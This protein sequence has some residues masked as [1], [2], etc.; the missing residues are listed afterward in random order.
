MNSRSLFI[1]AAWAVLAGC[2]KPGDDPGRGVETAALPAVTVQTTTLALEEIPVTTEITGTVQAT[3]R[4][5]LASKLMGAIE[6]MPVSLGQRVKAGEVLVKIAAGE[7]S[8]R[9]AQAR[10]QLNTT[11][12]DLDRERALQAKGAS[13]N[14]T[15]RNLED[16]VATHEAQLREAEVMLGYTILRAPFDGVVSRKISNQ[17]DLAT[18][19]TTLLEVHGNAGFEVDAAVPETAASQLAVDAGVSV[20]IPATNVT[21]T[22]KIAEISSAVDTRA[23]AVAIKVAVPEGVEVRSGQFARLELPGEPRR[24]IRVPASAVSRFGQIERVF[25][26][27]D[28][29]RAVLRLVKTAGARQDGRVEILAGLV[30]GDRVVVSPPPQL[31]EG[32]RVEVRR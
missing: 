20:S 24:A 21:F 23:R 6:E 9:V 26:V 10:T 4:A 31:R 7:I 13:T 27:A 15:V 12:R 25:T 29:H 8:A 2:S 11:Q 32:Q 18:P 28:D 16:R 17:G 3:Q 22:G 1:C 19:G 14:E 5:L 30:A